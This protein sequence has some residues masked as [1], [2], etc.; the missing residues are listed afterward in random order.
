MI[1]AAAFD[2]H[3]RNIYRRWYSCIYLRNVHSC[4]IC[5][6]YQNS[7]FYSAEH[8]VDYLLLRSIRIGGSRER[9]VLL[10]SAC[11]A[12]DDGTLEDRCWYAMAADLIEL[13]PL[14]RIRL[15]VRAAACPA[16]DGRELPSP[17]ST[18]GGG[19]FGRQP[20]ESGVFI[21]VGGVCGNG[22]RWLPPTC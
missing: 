14:S 10:L 5:L 7:I 17:S 1:H 3:H 15:F 22:R 6:S 16:I 4:R 2:L 8:C 21:I 13:S 19:A 11:V 20:V 18:Y 9:T 12:A